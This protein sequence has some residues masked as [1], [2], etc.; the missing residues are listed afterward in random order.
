MYILLPLIFK[1][2][3]IF[4]IVIVKCSRRI[5]SS[6]VVVVVVIVVVVT[7]VLIYYY[8][9]SSMTTPCACVFLYQ[10]FHIDLVRW[11]F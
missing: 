1:P 9:F 2:V 10:V 11:S 7:V 5:T 8:Y 3:S 6:S 4:T